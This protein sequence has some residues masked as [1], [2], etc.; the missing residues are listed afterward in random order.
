MNMD[1]E[2]DDGAN[3]NSGISKNEEFNQ[4]ASK[5]DG[6]ANTSRNEI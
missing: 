3:K 1:F 6:A 2:E 5:S 4:I